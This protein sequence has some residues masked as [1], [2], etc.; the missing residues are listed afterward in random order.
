MPFTS[1]ARLFEGSQLFLELKHN[2]AAAFTVGG[3]YLRRS[4]AEGHLLPMRPPTPSKPI[5]RAFSAGGLVF[6]PVGLANE[7][8][9]LLLDVATTVH[10]INRWQPWKLFLVG[11]DEKSGERTVPTSALQ[12]FLDEHRRDVCLLPKKR[13]IREA[14]EEASAASAPVLLRI[15]MREMLRLDVMPHR[16]H[17]VVL[18]AEPQ[19]ARSAQ[20]AQLQLKVCRDAD[21]VRQYLQWLR[22]SDL[23]VATRRARA[24]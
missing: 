24:C 4:L 5:E 23:E 1:V 3:E 13:W 8:P 21:S 11:V 6:A 19:V 22:R 20:H 14:R 15:A 17:A 2:P 7:Q 12:R 18:S 10:E 9:Q 16:R